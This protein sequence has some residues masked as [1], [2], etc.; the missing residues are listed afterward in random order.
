MKISQLIY[1]SV[2]YS[3]SDSEIGLVNQ[4]GYRVYS[5]TQGLT[6]NEINEIVRFCGYRLPKDCEV[7]YSK[8]PFDPEIPG[9]FP[10]TFR[11]F[12]TETGKYVAVQ[13]VYSGFDLN[14]E[15][16]NFFAHAMIFEDAP[17][18]FCP[19][20]YY[21]SSAFRK[22]LTPEEVEGELVRYL[23]ALDNP[24][25]NEKL[26]DEI[27]SF[28]YNHKVQMS[29]VLE[30][31]MAVFA[32]NGKTHICISAKN[33][34]ESDYY[35]LG[36][37]RILP[38]E[39]SDTL[40]IS[41]NNIFLPST[42][43]S[44]IVIN[45]TISGKNNISD[46]DIERRT[47]CVYIDVQRIET[48]GVKPM[49]LFEM[50]VEE[51]YDSYKKFSIK[52]GKQLQIWM[53]SFERLNEQGVGE[54]LRALYNHVGEQLF[55]ERATALYEKLGQSDFKQVKFE[56]LEVMFEHIGLFESIADDIVYALA[57]EGIN[58]ICSGEPKNV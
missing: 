52:N 56:I 42:G 22:W 15:D 49:K 32:D 47:N 5:C 34:E 44:K 3:L 26:F 53:N 21:G 28:V 33:Q 31:A 41:T 12:K 16:G 35:V 2:K 20:A 36:L 48:D 43:Q 1:T 18:G 57:T 55:T 14:G 54:R 30:Q 19:E 4:P 11:T 51:L 7:K 58:C 27:D 23:P 29:S 8:T 13:V 10:Q 38:P 39:F 6:E 37:K 50:T 46:D 17:E 40:G 25:H 9:L 24:E 45:G